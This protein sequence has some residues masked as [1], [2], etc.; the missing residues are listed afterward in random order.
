MSSATFLL[1]VNRLIDLFVAIFELANEEVFLF[2][3][4]PKLSFIDK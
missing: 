2:K 3:Q 1:R 4:Q